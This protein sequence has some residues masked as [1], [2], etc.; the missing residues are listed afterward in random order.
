[1][2]R[3][4]PAVGLLTIRLSTQSRF[5][6]LLLSLLIE[7]FLTHKEDTFFLSPCILRFYSVQVCCNYSSYY[8]IE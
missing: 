8:T 2:Y 3:V 7:S 6:L 5:K 4:G 1:M